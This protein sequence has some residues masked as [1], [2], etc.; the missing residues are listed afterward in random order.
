MGFLPLGRG[1]CGIFHWAKKCLESWVYT[2][3]DP[4]WVP[5]TTDYKLVAAIIKIYATFGGSVF[6][7]VTSRFA[8]WKINSALYCMRWI[9]V[10]D[11]SFSFDYK[12]FGRIR[13]LIIA[14]YIFT[15]F[16]I[17]VLFHFNSVKFM[18]YDCNFLIVLVFY[19]LFIFDYETGQT[20]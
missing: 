11:C 9:I 3:W 4:V 1:R 13:Y 18:F 15:V 17:G 16:T 7:S 5:E 14:S 8:F 10:I 2:G 19:L 12:F 20:I 6:C